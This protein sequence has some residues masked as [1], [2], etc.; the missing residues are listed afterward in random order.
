LS[1]QLDE[2]NPETFD[3]LVE[4]IDHATR[5]FESTSN[6][7]VLR[8]YRQ[9][10]LQ[11]EAIHGHNTGREADM[12]SSMSVNLE[13]AEHE[14]LRQNQNES[15]FLIYLCAILECFRDEAY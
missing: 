9:G 8:I 12:G 14:T 13:P 6:H 15:L 11:D 1:G 5:A 3:R 4:S 7:A 10:L 2:F